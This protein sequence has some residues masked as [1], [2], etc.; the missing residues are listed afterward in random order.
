MAGGGSSELRDLERRIAKLEG[1]TV[2]DVSGLETEVESALKSCTDLWREVF[3]L[4][5]AL[6]GQQKSIDELRGQVLVQG[7][8]VP[9]R[10][11]TRR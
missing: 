4:Q 10:K 9:P 2:L 1:G 8:E 7:N 3:D 5:Q 11:W 6:K